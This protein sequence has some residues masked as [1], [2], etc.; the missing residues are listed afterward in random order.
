MVMRY[1]S[2]ALGQ[3]HVVA[4][5]PGPLDRFLPERASCLR[6]AGEEIRAAQHRQGSAEQPLVAQLAG[7]LDRLFSKLPCRGDVNEASGARSGDQRRGE[8]R[9]V[10]AGVGPPERRHEQ[11]E[12]LLLPG[13]ALPVAAR[14][15]RPGAAPARSRPGGRPHDPAARRRLA[16]S[17]SSRASQLP[18][19]ARSGKRP[20][21][22]RPPGNARSAPRRP[23]RPRSS[24]ASTSRSAANSRIVSSSRYRRAVPGGLGHDQALVHQRPEQVGDIQH[25]QAAG[26]AHRLGRV[27]AEAA[28]EHRQAPQQHLLGAGQQRIR[29][30]DGR[31]QG[32]LAFQRG[33]AAPG[34]QPEP[35]VQPVVQLG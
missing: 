14:A 10:G 4:E 21:P 17:A 6:L 25:V 26:P 9:G 13:A 35:L 18:A 20:P 2:Q 15:R 3:Q 34:Q 24:P 8:Q 11:P 1:V 33:A 7:D 16:W 22:R 5:P 27:Q 32:L 23:R 29:P 28:G 19:P 12:G 31:P 30:G